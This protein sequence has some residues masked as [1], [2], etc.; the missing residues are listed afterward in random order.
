[1]DELEFGLVEN[2]YITLREIS[3]RNVIVPKGFVFDGVTVKAPFTLLFSQ[4]N[5][6]NGIRAS[7]F[8]DYMCKRKTLYKRSYSTKIL[9]KLWKNDG[10]GSVKAGIVYCLVEMYQYLRGWK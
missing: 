5:L 4:K 7:C 8:H 10:L 6:R 1:M 9:V 2:G 3:F